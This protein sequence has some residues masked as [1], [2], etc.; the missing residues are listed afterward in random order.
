MRNPL[1]VP[2][3]ERNWSHTGL[4]SASGFWWLALGL[5]AI[6]TA[7]FAIAAL[8]LALRGHDPQPWA[9]LAILSGVAVSVATVFAAGLGK[10]QRAASAVSG[11]TSARRAALVSLSSLWLAL[12]VFAIS[13]VHLLLGIATWPLWAG[14]AAVIGATLSIG[15]VIYALL[16]YLTRET[17]EYQR[18]LLMRA[19]LIAAALT[20]F[21]LTAWGLLELYV[22]AP[23][24]PVS[25]ALAP[26]CLF[27]A[28][29]NWWVRGRT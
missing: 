13:N 21:T 1:K 11:P 15:A 20:F 4:T 9:T 7:F 22:G 26:F 29:T 24:L 17:D 3:A 25:L 2:H 23:H 8:L 28:I 27:F 5:V 12:C 6:A 18:L 10:Q 14:L 16:R 19:A